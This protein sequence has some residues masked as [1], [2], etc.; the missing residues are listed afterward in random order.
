MWYSFG[1]PPE[2]RRRLNVIVHVSE[3]LPAR[4]LSRVYA[5]DDE[6]SGDEA[7]GSEEDSVRCDL[8]E[9]SFVSNDQAMGAGSG[10]CPVPIVADVD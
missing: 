2:L 6:Q 9:F 3:P 7:E 5:V 4:V 10:G 8:P 1:M